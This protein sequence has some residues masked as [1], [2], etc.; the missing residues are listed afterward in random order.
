MQLYT[1]APR[2][3]VLDIALTQRS[4]RFHGGVVTDGDDACHGALVTGC[5]EDCLDAA[6]TKLRAWIGV[7]DHGAGGFA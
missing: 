4:E 6:G 2:S 5:C 7:D 3:G 1:G